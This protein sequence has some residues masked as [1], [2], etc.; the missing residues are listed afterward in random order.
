[1]LVEIISPDITIYNGE[2]K[3]LQVPGID[4]LFEILDRHAPLISIL[5]KG[6]IKLTD[7]EKET[8]FFDIKGGVIEVAENK[9][10]ILAE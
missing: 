7:S 8:R 9:V 1:M 2:A 6:K 3:L 5:K 4:G 10:M